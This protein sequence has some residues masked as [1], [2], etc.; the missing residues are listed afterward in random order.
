MRFPHCVACQRLS[1]KS[2]DLMREYNA[3]FDALI[4]TPRGHPAYPDR[5]TDLSKASQRLYEAQRREAV[6]QARYHGS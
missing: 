1:K 6:H 3:V 2:A 4:S 5:W